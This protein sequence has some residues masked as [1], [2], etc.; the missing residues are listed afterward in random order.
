MS[1][2][3]SSTDSRNMITDFK[4]ALNLGIGVF[5][6]VSQVCLLIIEAFKRLNLVSESDMM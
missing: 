3:V 6:L 1:V 2:L 5:N 4:L